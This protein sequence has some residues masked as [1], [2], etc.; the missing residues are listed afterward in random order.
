[1]RRLLTAVVPFALFIVSP[2]SAQNFGPLPP[3]TAHVDV[4]VVNVDVTVTDRHGKPV[5]DLTR[6]DF[7][8][9]EDGK[10]AKVTNFSVIEK[11]LV[12]Q[13]AAAATQAQQE[14]SSS[15]EKVRR[16]IVLL[17]D[18]NYVGNLERNAALRAF[19]KQLDT[20]Y[21]G[22]YDW[23]VATIGH[24]LEI[25]Q[26]FTNQKELIHA[27]LGRVQRS[28]TFMNQHDIDRSILSD[29]TRK[30]L[31]F[32]TDAYD[33]GQTV[34]FQ[35]R[36][37]T[38]QSIASLQNTARA[39]AEMARAHAA[40]DSKK[41][42]IL[43]TGGIENNA[44]FTAY[45]KGN[46]P[47]MR[48][49]QLERAK[50]VDAIVQEANAANFTIHVVNARARGMQAPQHDV[51]N[52]SSGID[53]TSPNF[54]QR[55]GGSDPIDVS[56]VDS[57]P[58]S[59][60]LGTGGSYLPS[61]DIGH[62]FSV[63]D[64]Q[65]S[66]F[67]SLGYSPAHNGDRQYHHIR[68]HVKR[69]GVLVANRVG[70]YDLTSDDRLEQTLRA[71]MTFDV[72]T[73]PLPVQVNMGQP[74]RFDKKIVLPLTA[75]LPI[76]KLT[77]LPREGSYVGRVHVYVS[78]FNDQGQN[79]GFSHQLQEVTMTTAQYQAAADPFRY[80]LNV[81]LQKGD[82]TVVVTLRDDLSNELGSSV[83]EVRL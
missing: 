72:P 60:A 28:P 61:T 83:K 69:A 77:M 78:V 59:I 63:I 49:L 71:R 65:T 22:D 1:M 30:E 41:Y 9:F 11:A 54:F 57:I 10:L 35:S 42:M 25:V 40:D 7:E 24:A 51:E 17:V 38:F 70:Y 56:N 34:R 16:R 82:F 36:E 15:P 31:D 3:L 64:A 68:V 4:N 45:D 26:P 58:L 74:H 46:D 33:Y 20:I 29:R 13:T 12:R 52:K 79:V 6:N 47:Y 80:T 39:V 53:L 48:T 75:A 76:N 27:A 2:I 18:N 81:R 21:A 19:E 43:L 37:Q 44:S 66:N 73:G 32:Q 50:L 8:V 67:Y 5:M 23:A 62:S 14:P 55:G